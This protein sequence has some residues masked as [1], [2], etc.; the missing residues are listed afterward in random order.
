MRKISYREAVG[1]LLYASQGTRPDISF[2]VNTVSRYMQNPGKG[3]WL[4]VKRIFRYLKGTLNT[5]L[6]FSQ[7]QTAGC[8]GYCD[9]DWGNDSD[10]RRSITGSIFLFQGGL[11]VWQSKR[12]SSVALSTTEAEYMALSATCQEALW[13]RTLAKDLEPSIVSSPTIILNDNKGAIDLSN[14]GGYRPRTKHIDIRHHFIREKVDCGEVKIEHI[15]TE[16]MT[17]DVL[18][19]ALYAPKIIDCI[20]NM[21]LM[22]S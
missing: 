1:S 22:F 4:A 19:K 2:A 3:H 6:E 12:Q 11:I 10:T 16:R 9:A 18:T 15:P 21:G 17:A 5:K 8:V 7:S 13:L 20:K 14:N